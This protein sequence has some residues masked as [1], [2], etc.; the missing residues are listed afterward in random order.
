[1]RNSNK[2]TNRPK[3]GSHRALKRRKLAFHVRIVGVFFSDD[4]GG[5]FV[6]SS[7]CVPILCE[8]IFFIEPARAQKKKKTL[9]F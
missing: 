3:K 1:V 2:R 8:N 6:F 9:F 5:I 4:P 7:I